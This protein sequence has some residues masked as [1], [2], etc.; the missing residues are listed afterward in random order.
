MDDREAGSY[1]TPPGAAPG[2]RETDAARE[3][4]AKGLPTLFASVFI[5]FV[6]VAVI[7]LAVRYAF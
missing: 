1:S 5:T 7:L 3:R 6:I 4:M 2:R